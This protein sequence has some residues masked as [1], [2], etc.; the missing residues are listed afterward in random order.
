MLC[1]VLCAVFDWHFVFRVV[2]FVIFWTVL[3]CVLCVV[4]P[5]ARPLM[6]LSYDLTWK[7]I[8]EHWSCSFSHSSL[9]IFIKIF[10]F[11][12]VRSLNW[13]HHHCTPLADDIITALGWT[14]I[15]QLPISLITYCFRRSCYHRV[16]DE[17]HGGQDP[18]Q[19]NMH[20]WGH[21][22]IRRAHQKNKNDIHA[23]D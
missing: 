1:F 23:L 16:R 21:W 6:S 5:C 19:T 14:C 3:C 2:C 20:G 7:L 17:K 8:G 12:I 15:N 13:W 22:L 4:L 10:I 18:W 11:L 9:F